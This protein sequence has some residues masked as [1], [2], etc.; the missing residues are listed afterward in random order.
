[1]PRTNYCE[2]CPEMYSIAPNGRALPLNISPC[3][4]FLSGCK[5]S[6]ERHPQ[7]EWSAS[8]MGPVICPS[9]GSVFGPICTGPIFIGPIVGLILIGFSFGS[10]LLLPYFSGVVWPYSSGVVGA[11]LAAVPHH[12]YLRSSHGNTAACGRC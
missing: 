1:M 2:H 12:L 4:Y 11:V 9:V 5:L 3:C 8:S 6:G 10:S 7:V